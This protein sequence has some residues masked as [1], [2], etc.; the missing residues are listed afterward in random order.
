MFQNP[1]SNW[2]NWQSVKTIAIMVNRGRKLTRGV[3]DMCVTDFP[4]I[5]GIGFLCQKMKK[6]TQ[7]CF[8]WAL[9]GPSLTM[10]TLQIPL[11]DKLLKENLNNSISFKMLKRILLN[12]QLNFLTLNPSMKHYKFHRIRFCN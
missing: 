1:Y 6:A 2:L 10:S 8:Q 12:F 11:L 3:H 5:L 9:F 4:Q 7:S